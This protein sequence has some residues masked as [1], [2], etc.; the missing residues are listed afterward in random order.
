MNRT[1][2]ELRQDM[3]EILQNLTIAIIRACAVIVAVAIGFAILDRRTMTGPFEFQVREINPS[4]LDEQK[5]RVDK[6]LEA[7]GQLAKE[8]RKMEVI[9]RN[10]PFFR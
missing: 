5:S 9:W 6:L 8:D 2:E 10:Y 3:I 7:F 1:F 4:A